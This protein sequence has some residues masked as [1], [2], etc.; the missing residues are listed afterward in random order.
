MGD[1]GGIGLRRCSGT[2][3]LYFAP[4][5]SQVAANPATEGAVTTQ[6]ASRYGRRADWYPSNWGT[7][8][9]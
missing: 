2:L 8:F 3:A 1:C 6:C 7:G 5:S 4:L 9:S